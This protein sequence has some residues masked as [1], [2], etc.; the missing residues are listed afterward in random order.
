LGDQIIERRDEEAGF[1]LLTNLQRFRPILIRIFGRTDR[2]SIRE[3]VEAAVDDSELG[4]GATSYVAAYI[5]ADHGLVSQRSNEA[6][7]E[8]ILSKSEVE[9]IGTKLAIKIKKLAHSNTLPITSTID[10]VLR[11]WTTF[12]AKDE[13]RTWIE[14]NL[15]DPVTFT[16]IAFSQMGEVSSSDPPYR[17]RELH[18]SLDEELFDLRQMSDLGKRHQNSESLSPKDRDDLLRFIAGLESQLS[19]PQGKTAADR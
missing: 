5:G 8:S 12:G 18:G 10:I 1:Y 9:Q 14:K 13:A 7:S 3:A 19:G 4:V 6:R 15:L 2:D 17:Y 16:K 11:V